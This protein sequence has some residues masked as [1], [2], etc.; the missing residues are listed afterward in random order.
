VSLTRDHKPA[1]SGEQARVCEVS[2]VLL[3]AAVCCCVPVCCC[4]L[5]LRAHPLHPTQPHTQAGL[6]VS[7]NRVIGPK[8]SLAMSRALGDTK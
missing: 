6:S 8:S 5:L 3:C 1:L 4:V 2:C 7:E